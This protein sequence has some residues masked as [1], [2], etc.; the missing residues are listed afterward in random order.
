[1][2]IDEAAKE[3]GADGRAQAKDGRGRHDG[4]NVGAKASRHLRR[5]R[6]EGEGVGAD[7]ADADGEQVG[8]GRDTCP[9]D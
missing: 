4:G 1:M 2:A 3:N 8:E 7:D 6:P 9:V 5:D